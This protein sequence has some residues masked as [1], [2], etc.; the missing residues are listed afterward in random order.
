MAKKE[1]EEKKE[2]ESKFK[3][4]RPTDLSEEQKKLVA[5]ID[6]H[7]KNDP[8]VTNDFPKMRLWEEWFYGNQYVENIGGKLTDLTPYIEREE[9]NVYNKIMP[10]VR[11]IW[12]ELRYPHE[13]YAEPATLEKDDIKRARI[14]SIFTEFS[15]I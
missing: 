2:E 14:S 1:K 4:V 12:G 7:W 15:K 5:K 3:P 11:Q 8:C 13:F 9:C 6:N 10:T